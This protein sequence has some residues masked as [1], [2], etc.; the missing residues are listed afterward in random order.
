MRK[1]V[2]S[3]CSKHSAMRKKVTIG[4]DC[5][6]IIVYSISDKKGIDG[7]L[8][9][10]QT[11]LMMQE[12]TIRRNERDRKAMAEKLSVLDRTLASMESEKRQQEVCLVLYDVLN[13]Y[14][15]IDIVRCETLVR[16]NC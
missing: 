1:A 2:S 9:S 7:R 5:G 14:F 12:E 3:N 8:S 6:V 15:G 10:A 13:G 11:A 4:V 16:G